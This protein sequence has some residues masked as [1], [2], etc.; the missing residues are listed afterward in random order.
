MKKYITLLA[1]FVGTLTAA[2]LRLAWK[3][4]S[5]NEAGFAIERSTGDTAN[6]TEIA[7]VGP[8]VQAYTDTGLPNDT[9]FSYRIR[10]FNAAGFSGYTAPASGRTV[11]AL[12]NGDPSD[13]TVITVTVT[14]TVQG[15]SA[16]GVTVT[17]VAPPKA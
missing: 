9:V 16:G 7:R 10:A 2:D 12:P 11:I 15:R 3:D 13:L 4:N 8:D 17:Q 5:T 14:I 6:W 1:L